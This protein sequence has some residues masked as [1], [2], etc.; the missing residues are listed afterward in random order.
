MRRSA[1]FAPKI[2]RAFGYSCALCGVQLDIVEAAHIIGVSEDGSTDEL[3]NGLAFCPSHHKVFD[4]RLLVV[5]PSLRVA[6]DEPIIAFLEREGRAEGAQ[7][8]LRSYRGTRLR[9]PRFWS[10]AAV[11]ERMLCGDETHGPQSFTSSSVVF[12]NVLVLLKGPARRQEASP[13]S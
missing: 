4:A 7:G 8:L 12:Q 9:L 2:R 3:W 10:D 13:D 6:L 5:L 11:R 1:S